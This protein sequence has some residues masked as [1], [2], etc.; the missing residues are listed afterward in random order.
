V[1]RP[2]SMNEAA[3]IEP[4]A[5]LGKDSSAL[6]IRGIC[7]LPLYAPRHSSRHELS[8]DTLIDGVTKVPKGCSEGFC[9]FW[10]LATLGFSRNTRP[11]HPI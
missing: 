8:L 4:E 6:L 3:C 9:H 7:S 5:A 1:R 10:H 11:P 2:P